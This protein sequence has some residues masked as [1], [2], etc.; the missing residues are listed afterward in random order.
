MGNKR[1]ISD[2]KRNNA[3]LYPLYK[4][5]SW[6]LICFYSIE[7]LFYTMAKGVTASE[8][9]IINAFYIIFKIVMQIPAV[10]IADI[11]GKRK[12]III[13]NILVMLYLIVLIY[14]PGMIGIIIANAICAL[15]YDIKT[16]GET[17]LLY[18]S[19]ST[20]GGEGLYS[21]LDSKGG[22]WYYWLDGIICLTAGYL[23]KLNHYLPIFICLGFVL[24][25]TIL[26]FEFRDIHKVK[27]AD[28][29]SIKGIL[30][31]YIT[32][33]RVS[34]KFIV[35]SNRMKAYILFGAVFY[36]LIKV[37]D[38][39]K[40]ELLVAK[41]IPEE[42]FAMIF[43]IMTILAGVAA[44]LS[45]KLHKKFRNK[46]LTVVS[47][48]YSVAFIITGIVTNVLTD[49]LAIPI[50]I[51][52]YAALKMCSATWFILKYKYMTN[53]S[54]PEMRNR[55]TFTYEL[56][57][58]I[59]AS[60][61]SVIGSFILDK[62]GINLSFLLVGIIGLFSLL[63]VLEY[64]KPRFGLKPKQYKKEDLEMKETIKNN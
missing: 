33:L 21:K 35:K 63:F 27:K 47:M 31:E 49:Y 59:I 62:L 16:I 38:T 61:I 56:I 43:A 19:V 50:I 26:S 58:G 37:G 17:N 30:K 53:F 9:L 36:G 64:M 55:I 24:I 20:K 4:M 15:G 8:V 54:E 45:R 41:G 44:N 6:D 7:F 39:Y 22:S 32:D 10:A 48:I 11:L 57:S 28:R 12:G 60:T 46:T 42:Q 29:K 14:A 1:K 3:R 25:A 2:N 13:G 5:F 18:D 34:T 52:M 40:G 51:L 23:F